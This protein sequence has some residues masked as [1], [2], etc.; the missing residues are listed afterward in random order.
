MD[1]ITG[2]TQLAISNLTPSQQDVVTGLLRQGNRVTC[3][4]GFRKGRVII[5][6]VKTVVP[7]S[8][9][10]LSDKHS[11]NSVPRET[12][13]QQRK[14]EVA[15][16]KNT[17]TV[18]ESVFK[19][20][21]SYLHNKISSK[22]SKAEEKQKHVDGSGKINH[23]FSDFK[24][25]MKHENW[26]KIPEKS[27]EGGSGELQEAVKTHNESIDK[28]EQLE[29]GKDNMQK[30]LDS[31]NKLYK[32]TRK[33][34]VDSQSVIN[35]KSKIIVPI[36][37]E[38]SEPVVIQSS[39]PVVRMG[40]V[41]SIR[42]QVMSSGFAKKLEDLE[43]GIRDA[44]KAQKQLKAKM[45]Q[46][47]N[48]ILDLFKKYQPDS[49][50]AKA[51]SDGLIEKKSNLEDRKAQLNE[52]VQNLKNAIDRLKKEKKQIKNQ[53]AEDKVEL[54]RFKNSRSSVKGISDRNEG[55]GQLRKTIN[56]NIE[57]KN[58]SITTGQERL[59]EIPEAIKSKEKELDKKIKELDGLKKEG[60]ELKNQEKADKKAYIAEQD[61]LKQQLGKKRRKK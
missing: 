5:E 16:E 35:S 45:K 56:E 51:R 40:Q 53:L 29:N 19:K 17:A 33:V 10:K 47:G 7:T 21:K 41:D 9:L 54:I 26:E 61:M 18:K 31:L 15:D 27:V 60:K 39:N 59:D 49:E 44:S 12:S 43:S 23:A 1:G 34:L 25:A 8:G 24:K 20:V 2:G 14:T 52:E 48:E 55:I 6:G 28:L 30:E 32:N 57:N 46:S 11:E 3:T 38:G 13:L 37:L 36:P 22:F 58:A 42:N 4:A 50:Q